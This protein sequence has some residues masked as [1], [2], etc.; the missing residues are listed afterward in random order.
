MIFLDTISIYNRYRLKIKLFLQS[1]I[2]YQKYSFS[3][4]ELNKIFCDF[5]NKMK[6]TYM[7]NFFKNNNNSN[8]LEKLLLI[9]SYLFKIL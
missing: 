1:K 7:Y 2:N 8:C 4:S 9:W 3:N 5:N 6:K